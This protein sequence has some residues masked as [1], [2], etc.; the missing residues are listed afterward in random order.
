MVDLGKL[1]TLKKR[2]LEATDFFEV[3][4]YFMEHFGQEPELRTLGEPLQD[5]TLIAV[6]EQVGARTVGVRAR[7]TEPF[8]LRLAEHHLVHGAFVL[9]THLGTVFYFADIDTGLAAFGAIDSDGPNQLARFSVAKV[10]VG[11]RAA[12]N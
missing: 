4:G 1:A 5:P 12:P 10:P 3:Y 8:L 7:I 9:G 6:L 2:L 11:K